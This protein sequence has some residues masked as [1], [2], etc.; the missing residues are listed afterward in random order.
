MS[1]FSPGLTIG[2]HLLE[3]P[4]YV[5]AGTP[6]SMTSCVGDAHTLGP[7]SHKSLSSS[8]A[9]VRRHEGE[10]DAELSIYQIPG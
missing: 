2:T 5:G 4:P 7:P 9:G 8:L 6:R 1:T 10:S 3:E